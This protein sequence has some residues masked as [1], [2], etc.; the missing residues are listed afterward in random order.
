MWPFLQSPGDNSNTWLTNYFI[1]FISWSGNNCL[2]K[3]PSTSDFFFILSY[4]MPRTTTGSNLL[5]G[6]TKATSGCQLRVPFVVNKGGCWPVTKKNFTTHI[7]IL[8]CFINIFNLKQKRFETHV[9]GVAR[10]LMRMDLWPQQLWPK[11]I[12]H[13]SVHHARWINDMWTRN[14][15]LLNSCMP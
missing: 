8:Y 6:G 11:W 5:V 3:F 12:Q 2:Q 13:P 10:Q 14:T 4:K 7:N 9:V 1:L 15:Y